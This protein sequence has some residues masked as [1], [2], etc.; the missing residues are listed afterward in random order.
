MNTHKVESKQIEKIPITAN[1]RALMIGVNAL[2]AYGGAIE[3]LQQAVEDIGKQI[4]EIG[5]RESLLTAQSCVEKALKAI[6]QW[7]TVM[8]GGQQ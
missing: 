6:E 8:N 3:T 2:G 4:D 7:E 1:D 5:N